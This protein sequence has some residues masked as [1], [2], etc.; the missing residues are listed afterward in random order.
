[1]KAKTIIVLSAAAGFTGVALG[2]FGAHGLQDLLQGSGHTQTWRTAVDY[3]LMHALGLLALGVWRSSTAG[4][5]NRWIPR[6]AI[7]WAL[8]IV[9]F[10]GSLYGLSL[11]GPGV[12]GP[13][14]PLGGL[15]FLVG[16]AMLV[17]AAGGERKE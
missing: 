6:V 11:G 13:V 12:L 7:A 8:G 16:W 2:A 14:T 9:F 1:M 10:S 4:A 15:V 17:P 3:H 5:G